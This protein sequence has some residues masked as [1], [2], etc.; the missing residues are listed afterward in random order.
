[1]VVSAILGQNINDHIHLIFPHDQLAA[2]I[3]ADSLC[4]EI[5]DKNKWYHQP[6]KTKINSIPTNQRQ[7][8]VVVGFFAAFI[9]S[10]V[11]LHR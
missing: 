4:S 5:V 3:F 10:D 1:M 8:V 9:R 2:H 7:G 11:T 6:R